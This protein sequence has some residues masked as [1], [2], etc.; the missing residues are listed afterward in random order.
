MG[1]PSGC[2]SPSSTSR[3]AWHRTRAGF[4]PGSLAGC[5]NA[6]TC[7][8]AGRDCAPPGRPE[9]VSRPALRPPRPAYV[10]GQ[11]VDGVRLIS[12]VGASRMSGHGHGHGDDHDHP[13]L[14]CE[15]SSF[16]L[17]HGLRLGA[18]RL[19][20]ACRGITGLHLLLLPQHAEGPRAAQ[21]GRQCHA[22]RPPCRPAPGKSL[23]DAGTVGEELGLKG[24]PRL[25]GAVP[26][27]LAAR[28]G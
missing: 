18:P 20:F 14:P 24:G 3:R 27:A 16:A 23:L 28:R 22:G 7:C 1:G 10:L 9:R 25:A 13:S 11:P 15:V 8:S 5:W 2:A 17:E 19:R 12:S 4:A 21:P 6:P 26:L